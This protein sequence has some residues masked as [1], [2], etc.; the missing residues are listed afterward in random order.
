MHTSGGGC[1]SPTHRRREGAGKK[2]RLTPECLVKNGSHRPTIHRLHPRPLE[3]ASGASGAAGGY[4]RCPLGNDGTTGR[5]KPAPRPAR[6]VPCT[7]VCKAFGDRLRRYETTAHVSRR[8]QNGSPPDRPVRACRTGAASRLVAAGP[9]E[10]AGLEVESTVR[11]SGLFPDC[12]RPLFSYTHRPS[13]D[14]IFSKKCSRANFDFFEKMFCMGSRPRTSPRHTTTK[15]TKGAG[16]RT[17]S[18]RTPRAPSR[19]ADRRRAPRGSP[20]AIPARRGR[21]VRCGGGF[22]ALKQRR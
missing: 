20:A 2:L 12:L 1:R 9:L 21:G 4:V 3:L 6:A 18:K 16:A 8:L 10:P 19:P 15:R 5:R 22:D 17:W 7:A 11:Q 13:R 14:P